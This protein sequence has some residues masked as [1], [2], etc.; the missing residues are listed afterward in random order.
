MADCSGTN[1]ILILWGKLPVELIGK[2]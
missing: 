2:R 1:F